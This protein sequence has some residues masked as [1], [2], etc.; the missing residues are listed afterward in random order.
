MVAVHVVTCPTVG[1]KA[2]PVGNEENLLSQEDLG[3]G[4]QDGRDG[5]LVSPQVCRHLRL[6][7]YLVADYVSVQVLRHFL[8]LLAF[9]LAFP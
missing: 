8:T 3:N 4:F 1:Q 6:S 2:A 5:L 7:C 9:P